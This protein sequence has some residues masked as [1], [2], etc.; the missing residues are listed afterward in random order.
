[1][2]LKGENR[3]PFYD[4]FLLFMT[5]SLIVNLFGGSIDVENVDGGARLTVRL[6]IGV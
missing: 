5:K 2:V 4:P 1:M 6:K 3:T